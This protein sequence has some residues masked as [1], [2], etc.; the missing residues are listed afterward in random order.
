M[1]FT[2][3]AGDEVTADVEDAPSDIRI[4]E[5]A[6]IDIRYDPRNPSRA[7]PA[8]DDQ[9]VLSRWFRTVVGAVLIGLTGWA[10]W[11]APRRPRHRDR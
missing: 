9:A 8:G 7:V 6:P 3:G 5:G 10:A 4:A 1:R 11:R 2:T